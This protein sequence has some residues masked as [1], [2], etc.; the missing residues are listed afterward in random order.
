MENLLDLLANPLVL[1]AGTIVL[2]A[3]AAV[4]LYLHMSKQREET[5]KNNQRMHALLESNANQR[6]TEREAINGNLRGMS[7]SVVRMM[8]DISRTQQQQLDSFG[9]QIR[10]MSRTDEERMD[11]MRTT[12]ED[13]LTAYDT[14]MV[15]VSQTLEDKLTQNERRLSEMRQTIGESMARMQGENEKK[16]EQIRETVDEKLNSTLDKR[17]GES[18]RTVSDRLEQVY[19][20]LGEMQT[21]A[22]GVGDLKKMLTSVKTRGIWGE[23]QL[24]ALLEQVLAPGQ[25]E[26]NVAVKPGS[27]ERVEFAV[28][29]PGKEAQGAPVYL[30]IDAKFPAEDY[31]RLLDAQDVG[32]KQA[33]EAAANALAVTIRNEAKRIRI[34]YVDPPHTTDFAIMF[35]P[36]EGLFA[37]VLRRNGIVEQLQNDFRVVITGPTTLLA[38]LNSLQMGFR[39]MAIEQRSSEVWELLGAVK[40]EF[41]RFADLLTKTQKRLRQATDSIEVAA[42]KTRTIQRRLQNVQELSEKETQRLIQDDEM[43]PLPD[44]DASME[45][46]WD[47]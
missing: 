30:P 38:L 13:K 34:K 11:R 46:G 32:D 47:D 45:E 24:G 21:L 27:A 40:T 17:L 19:K 39:T 36:V 1:W 20:G 44:V 28:R 18:F 33:A 10:A 37:E 26:T 35:L 42:R 5:R 6:A 25:Y 29:L 14:Q 31:Q 12:I 16:L 8:G 41:G 9:G 7:D 43:E 4:P 15:R 22:V 3:I 2:L 23:V